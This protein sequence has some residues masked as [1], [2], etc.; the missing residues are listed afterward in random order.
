MSERDIESEIDR[1]TAQFNDFNKHDPELC[2]K[3]HNAK[4]RSHGIDIPKEQLLGNRVY[5]DI[6]TEHHHKKETGERIRVRMGNKSKS[7]KPKSKPKYKDK[8]R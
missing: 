7:D 1:L 3:L 2:G 8:R 6:L 5:N 4:L